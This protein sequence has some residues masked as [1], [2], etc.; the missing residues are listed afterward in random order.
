[1]PGCL[2]VQKKRTMERWVEHNRL[3]HLCKQLAA[4]RGFHE[5]RSNEFWL[6]PQDNLDCVP[7]PVNIFFFN[8]DPVTFDQQGT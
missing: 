1:M 6:D 3:F 7:Q 4:D 2:T 5:Q 8:G